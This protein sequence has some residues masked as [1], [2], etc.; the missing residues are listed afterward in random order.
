M[1]VDVDSFD[2]FARSPADLVPWTQHDHFVAVLIERN[3]FIPYARVVRNRSVFFDDE[4]LFFH[5][6]GLASLKRLIE[7]AQRA[8]HCRL[9]PV[10]I[11]C[12]VD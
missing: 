4:D 10:Q 11:R 6:K 1:P 5:N 8:K 9:S 2:N 12:L 3:G 7:C